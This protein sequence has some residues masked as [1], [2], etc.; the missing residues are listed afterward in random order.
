MTPRTQLET[1]LLD[2]RERT[3]DLKLSVGAPKP[4]DEG[5]GDSLVEMFR[6]SV[7]PTLGQVGDPYGIKFTA[8]EHDGR[9]AIKIEPFG[10]HPD[11][12]LRSALHR[13]Y[14]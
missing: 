11:P 9:P 4:L 6:L 14:G 8:V 5:R 2:L 12:D 1:F 7:T 10:D 3:P 13:T